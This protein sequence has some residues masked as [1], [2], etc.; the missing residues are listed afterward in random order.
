M[1]YGYKYLHVLFFD[2]LKFYPSLVK[3]INET[4]MLN[5][6][7]HFFITDWEDV[8]KEIHVYE[9]VRLVKRRELYKFMSQSKWIIFHS[10]PLKKW[11]VILLP[12]SIC[13]KIIWR[14]WGHDIRPIDIGKSHIIGC[15]KK[16]GFAIYRKKVELFFAIGI[17]IEFVIVNVED[18]FGYKFQYFK[19][20]YT[21]CS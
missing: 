11:Q 17:A 19:L 7:E 1:K 20:N 16:W 8:Y 15:L 12:N 9:N 5:P 21:D 18:A 10:M 14:T 3:N 2:D 4:K 13:E 6:N